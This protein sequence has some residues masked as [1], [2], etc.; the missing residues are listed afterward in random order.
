MPILLFAMGRIEIIRQIYEN[1]AGPPKYMLQI[2]AS[3]K[4]K[5]PEWEYRFWN[6]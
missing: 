1:P 5:M 4:K 3:W 2:A 6:R